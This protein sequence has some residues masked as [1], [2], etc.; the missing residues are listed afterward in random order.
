MAVAATEARALGS[1]TRPTGGARTRGSLYTGPVRNLRQHVNPLGL[2]YVTARARALRRPPGLSPGCRV[3]VELGCADGDFAFA[4]ARARPNTLVVG[5]EIREALV[6]RNVAKARRLGVDN[7]VF[8]Y[9]NMNV[10]LERVFADGEVDRFHLLF[11]DP[12]F[13]ARHRK[14]RVLDEG[15][16]RCLH[17]Q[18]RGDGELHFATDVYELGLHALAQL[19]DT[20]GGETPFTNLAGP[21]SFARDNPW[22]VESRRELTTRARGQRVWRLRF[23]RATP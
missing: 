21:W 12:W 5:L 4:L 18:L 1:S 7:L 14:R 17:R 8:A 6:E 9:V 19:E 20:A 16:C 13:K 22:G 23:G 15:L 2:Y 11:P 3:E 10:D